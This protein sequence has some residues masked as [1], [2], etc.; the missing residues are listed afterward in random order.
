MNIYEG[1]KCIRSQSEIREVE[2]EALLGVHRS[3]PSTSM[4]H[5][6][7][8]TPSDPFLGLTQAPVLKE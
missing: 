2:N 6:Q 8:S 1:L 4:K 3:L 5:V 7:G